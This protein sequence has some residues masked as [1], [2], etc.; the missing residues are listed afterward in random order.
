MEGGVANVGELRRAVIRGKCC[1]KPPRGQRKPARF[2]FAEW[3]HCSWAPEN[4]AP[5]KGR[6]MIRGGPPGLIIFRLSSSPTKYCQ[7][8]SLEVGGGGW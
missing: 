4:T 1:P 6:P 3:A 7:F 8:G 2:P 5:S